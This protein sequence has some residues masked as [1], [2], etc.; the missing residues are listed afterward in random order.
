MDTQAALKTKTAG[1]VG[2][3][4]RTLGQLWQVPAFL[5][6]LLALLL[7]AATVPLR[8]DSALG[9]FEDDLQHLREALNDKKAS[10]D[11]SV[12]LA[13]S[14][15]G[16]LGPRSR[17]AGLA[18]FLAGSV[19]QRLAEESPPDQAE[20]IRRQAL[21]YL[22]KALALGVPEEDNPALLYRL[23]QTLFETGT[24]MERALEYISQ[25][26]ERGGGQPVRGYAMLVQGYLRLPT[27][28]VEAALAANQ[29]QLDYCEGDD[30]YQARLVR[31]QLL[32]RLGK[33][34]EALQELEHIGTHAARDI[35]LKARTL[36]I[37]CCE[38]EG[39]WNQ[40][41]PLWKELLT[42]A[43][44]AAERKRLLY[45]LG[46]ACRNCDPPD[47]KEAEAAWHRAVDLG[48]EEA[49]AA[50]FGLAEMHLNGPGADPG[51]GLS[52]LTR[53]LLEVQSPDDYQNTL[54]T[55]ARVRNIF[56]NAWRAFQQKR[57]FV[58]AEELA[59]LYQ[60]VAEHGLA[61]EFQA[62]TQEARA[63][64]L[65]DRAAKVGG[66]HAAGWRTQARDL[67]NKA[68]AAYEYAAGAR[69]LDQ[70]PGCLWRSATCY[71]RGREFQKAIAVLSRFVQIPNT[72]AALAEA[73][74]A[75][76]EA[77]RSLGAKDEALKALFKCIE[78]PNT[79]FAY[80]A[81]IPLAKE[82]RDEGDLGQAESILTQNTGDAPDRETHATSLYMLGALQFERQ[83]YDRARITL[84]DA[85][86][87][88]P[89]D[90]RAF[91]ARD[92]RGVCFRK[93]AEAEAGK[94]KDSKL[95]LEKQAY[96]NRNM[97]GWLEEAAKTYQDLADDLEKQVRA[98]PVP[99]AERA[100][101]RKAEFEVA[102]LRYLVHDIDEAWRR[103]QLLFKKYRG[104]LEGL[105]ACQ[106]IWFC[107]RV[108]LEQFKITTPALARQAMEIA[109]ETV[110]EAIE[111]VERM[112]KDNEAF[113]GSNPSSREDWLKD[114]RD[115][116]ADLDRY[117]NATAN[118]P[119]V[120]STAPTKE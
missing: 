113:R 116:K 18:H 96:F 52:D 24:E 13:Q 95:T 15:I 34:R 55:L 19:Y 87:Q 120:Q 73:W 110:Q 117:F 82:A 10:S 69:A 2:R 58:R 97:R 63:G 45:S 104:E 108:R 59:V 61:Q 83:N 85:C 67:C 70:Q 94:L 112:D 17:K 5:F 68:G 1:K 91:A 12:S 26:V 25:A 23:G 3:A 78:F 115:K 105:F 77:H 65:E 71:Q 54:V 41:V 118:S 93:L 49:Q 50:C 36:Q 62:Q 43:G 86:Q 14:V 22:E 74:L 119:A 44:D 57:D 84:K 21:L 47:Y 111:D 98:K 72:D 42:D 27:P 92:Q 103:Y 9:E 46:R 89:D 76:A 51:I 32:E 114:L 4:S 80:R 75:L 99:P 39:L 30:E 107:A 31:G 16:R 90:P 102:D 6:G 101:W 60:K 11:S 53:A 106:R 8:Q 88:Y 100:L 48:G 64:D 28:N 109:R 40:S 20:P 7:V 66:D 38:Q 81:R 35:R 37:K 79:P 33:R 29:K 56:E